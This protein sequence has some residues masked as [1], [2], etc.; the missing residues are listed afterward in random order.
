M[1]RKDIVNAI[2]DIL[3]NNIEL[4]TLSAF[5][6]EA[7]LNED[8]YMDSLIILQLILHLELDHGFHIPDEIIVAKDFKTVVTLVN[9]LEKQKRVS[10]SEEEE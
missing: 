1:D 2:Y 3:K 10:R 4:P 7:R 5:H 6:E 9:F 8:L